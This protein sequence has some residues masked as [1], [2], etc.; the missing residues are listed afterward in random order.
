[1]REWI[2]DKKEI[3][4][5]FNLEA[6]PTEEAIVKALAP[7]LASALDWNGR[8]IFDLFQLTLEDANFHTLV[9][10]LDTLR[11]KHQV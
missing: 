1:M 5:N 4:I 9:A 10:E 11:E 3:K 2:M 7:E 8:L 6:I